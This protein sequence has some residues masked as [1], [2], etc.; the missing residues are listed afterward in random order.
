MRDEVEEEIKKIAQEMEKEGQF[1]SVSNLLGKTLSQGDKA[2]TVG[3]KLIEKA[4][5]QSA[6]TVGATVKSVG[7]G[8]GKSVGEAAGETLADRYKSD[9]TMMENISQFAKENP[10]LSLGG[11]GLASY[12]VPKF[13]AGVTQD[14]NKPREKH[15]QKIKQEVPKIT[16]RHGEEKV[17]KY[18]KS[19]KNL[20]PSFVKKDPHTAGRIMLQMLEYEGIDQPTINRLLETE[21]KLRE[22]RFGESDTRGISD[23]LGKL[24][25]ADEDTENDYEAIRALRDD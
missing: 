23:L 2:Q 15:L 1:Q 14:I 19:I 24:A 18:W 6:E 9:P 12:Q 7:E 3:Q 4:L 17:Q 5:K 16:E 22:Q 20:A 8:A 13:L 25:S 21:E 10:L 11:A